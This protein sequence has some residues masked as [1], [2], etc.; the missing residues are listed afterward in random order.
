M[1]SL[2]QPGVMKSAALATCITVVVCYPRLALWTDRPYQLWF[3]CFVLGWAAF[4]LWSFVFAWHRQYS[5][6]EV[7]LVRIGPSL[8]VAATVAGLIGSG[9]L[10]FGIDS[11]LRP[12]APED[13]PSTM[14]AWLA[15]TMFILAFDQLFVCFAPFALFLRLVRNRNVALG[16]TVSFGV[17]LVY[18]KARSWQG[19]FSAPFIMAL[20]A[21]RILASYLSVYFYLKGGVVLTWWWVF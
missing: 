3:L 7:L 1:R 19:Q 6:E 5:G 12:L 18:L 13:Y 4:M 15:M 9:F 8:W 21:W 17:F 11:I 14:R 16:L 20:F 2:V 10:H